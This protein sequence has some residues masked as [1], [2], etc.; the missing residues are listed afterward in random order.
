[1]SPDLSVI[2]RDHSHHGCEPL[3]TTVSNIAPGLH[4]VSSTATSV[5][6]YD[7]VLYSLS[8]VVC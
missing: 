5:G 7:A 4:A 3:A 1:M 2:S 6:T 8:L